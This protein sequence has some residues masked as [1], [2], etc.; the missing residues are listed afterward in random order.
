MAKGLPRRVEPDEK[1]I[2]HAQVLRSERIS[3]SFQRVTITG[4]A[5][6]GYSPLGLDQWFRL[7]LPAPGH[8]DM[9][10]PKNPGGLLGYAKFL[11]IPKSSRP[12]LRNYTTRAFRPGTDA[13]A[14]PELDIDFVLHG[15]DGFASAWASRAR[16]GDEVAILDEGILYVPHEQ[17]KRHLFVTDE[18]GLPAL[19]AVGE[20]LP[21]DAVG[22]AILEV[23]D[24]AD[25]QLV[26]LPD[27]MTLHLV[28]RGKAEKP[29]TAA[30]ARLKDLAPDLDGAYPFAIGESSL[31]TGARRHLVA[32][33]GLA[34]E[35][36][37]FCGYW[38]AGH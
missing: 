34:K 17:T 33:R 4:E 21:R 35:L 10:L 22:D 2:L 15:D 26:S 32:E 38:K 25:A 20:S 24:A 28:Q 37:T 27:G 13:G 12:A 30:L 6:T 18:T 14:L 7:F 9:R 29:G 31:A 3:G 19:A 11:T 8:T 5:L 23:T 1:V 36:M 16:A